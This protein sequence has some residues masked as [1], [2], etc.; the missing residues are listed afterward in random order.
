MEKINIVSAQ[1]L[2]ESSIAAT[3]TATK[4]HSEHPGSQSGP[5]RSPE[6]THEGLTEISSTIGTLSLENQEPRSGKSSPQLECKEDMDDLIVVDSVQSQEQFKLDEDFF[7]DE[8]KVSGDLVGFPLVPTP[9]SIKNG[10]GSKRKYD[11]D[12]A[13]QL[14]VPTLTRP[15]PAKAA[16]SKEDILKQR[17]MNNRKELGSKWFTFIPAKQSPLA[18]CAIDSTGNEELLS[19]EAKDRKKKRISLAEQQ[20]NKLLGDQMVI[21]DS[22]SELNSNSVP[23]TGANECCGLRVSEPSLYKNFMLS[24]MYK[25]KYE[26]ASVELFNENFID[27]NKDRV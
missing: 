10:S 7:V 21:E 3:L 14:C 11:Q 15:E 17:I 23:V 16:M 19:S 26:T 9:L 6:L 2:Q 5:N 20:L 22:V 25:S 27:G 24:K 12:T 13:V 1:N 4:Q 8:C 18:T